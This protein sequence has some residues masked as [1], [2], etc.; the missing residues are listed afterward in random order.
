MNNYSVYPLTPSSVERRK[1]EIVSLWNTNLSG[2]FVSRFDWFYKQNVCGFPETFIAEYTETGQVV[3]SNSL[4]PFYIKAFGK[5]I[6]I[7]VAV[8]FMI[9]QQF[10]VFGPALAIQKT[11]LASIE[12]SDL[13]FVFAYPNKAAKGVFLRSGYEVIGEVNYLTK[14]LKFRHKIKKL[15]GNNIIYNLLSRLIDYAM[16]GIERIIRNVCGNDYYTEQLKEC[17]ERVDALLK[18]FS[19]QREIVA[20]KDSKYLNWRYSRN[21][22]KDYFF[23]YLINKKN[24]LLEGYIVYCQEDQHITVWDIAFL[25]KKSMCVMLNEFSAHARKIGG[26]SISLTYLGDETLS[27]DLRINLFFN[28]KS[29]RCC[30]CYLNGG[31]VDRGEILNISNWLIFDGDLDL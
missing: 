11:I 13:N 21:Q 29:N 18:T 22:A 27:K 14:I 17:D 23:F 4:A 31:V 30:V 8:D 28:R 5:R 9:K 1:D 2:N 25:R 20:D 10:R 26:N 3:G 15:S 24:K 19:N 6:K 12:K 16:E 7:G